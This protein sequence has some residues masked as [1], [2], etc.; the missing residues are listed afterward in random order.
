MFTR[1]SSIGGKNYT[2]DEQIE[3]YRHTILHEGIDTGDGAY[4]LPMKLSQF[5]T[6][7]EARNAGL[8]TYWSYDD[9]N[10]TAYQE[11]TDKDKEF[12]AEKE[13]TF[14]MMIDG[15]EFW[16]SFK[17]TEIYEY[18]VSDLDF[19]INTDP[20]NIYTNLPY[21]WWIEHIC[22]DYNITYP[23]ETCQE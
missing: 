20:P 18:S 8:T 21:L 9:I 19:L 3:E 17:T 5:L 2:I 11:K 1:N 16:Y 14:M 23:A 10:N 12:I 22:R 6:S 4:F 15:R 7:K 13:M